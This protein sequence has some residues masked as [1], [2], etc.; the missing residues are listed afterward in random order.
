MLKEEDE[1]EEEGDEAGIEQQHPA[2]ALEHVLL[3]RG[4]SIIRIPILNFPK[5]T[6]ASLRV[7]PHAI[8]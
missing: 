7:A 8:T 3:V 5:C 2:A 1:E 6:P 4:H